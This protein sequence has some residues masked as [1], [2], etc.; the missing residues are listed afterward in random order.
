MAARKPDPKLTRALV[1]LS[2]K[3]SDG[4]SAEAHFG[5]FGGDP[6]S[7]LLAGLDETARLLALYGFG[8]EARATV[9]AALGRVAAWKA[10]QKLDKKGRA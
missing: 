4:Y 8:D 2:H 9:D 10:E 3:S 5:Q 1:S 6:K 7:A